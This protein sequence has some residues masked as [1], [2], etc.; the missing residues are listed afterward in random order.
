MRGSSVLLVGMSYKKNTGD[1]RESPAVRVADLLVMQGCRVLA[2]D[3]Y[4]DQL[5]SEGVEHVKLDAGVVGVT[6]RAGMPP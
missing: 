6:R 5:R 2:A 1:D 3:P 4:I